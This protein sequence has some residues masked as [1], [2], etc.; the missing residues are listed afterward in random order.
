MTF[1]EGSK[2]TDI[3]GSAF[4]Y[5]SNLREIQLPDGVKTI[6]NYAFG[7]DSKLEKSICRMA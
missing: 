4:Y 2:V 1:E 5:L 3:G 7:Y 6:G